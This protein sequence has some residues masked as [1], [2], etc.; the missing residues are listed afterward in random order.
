M[1]DFTAPI[2]DILFSLRHVAQAD[3]TPDWD[4]EMSGDILTHFANFAT[5]VLAPINAVGHEQG[6]KL[7]DGRVQMPDGFGA[8]YKELAEAG[9]QGL[10]APDQFDGMIGHPLLACAV[11]EVFSG[12]N[13][14]M[15]M[16]CNL[17]PGA[18]STLMQF[19]SDTQ[20]QNWV[21]RLASGELLSTM[22]LT[23]AGAG[24]DLSAIRCKAV[25]VVSKGC[26][27]FCVRQTWMVKE[28][29]FLS[30][31]LKRRWGFMPLQPA[32]WRLMVRMRN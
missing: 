16:V 2:D 21:P 18:I 13:H 27:C 28:T 10:S 3:S 11:S 22:C 26:H 17:V 20:K 19:G 14:S 25:T 12:A 32:R 15:Q 4:D 9:W 6:A 1:T 23:E 24:S 8:A 29:R 30:P 31:G 5:D 7:I